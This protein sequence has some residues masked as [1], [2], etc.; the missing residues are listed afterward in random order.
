[1]LSPALYYSILISHKQGLFFKTYFDFSCTSNTKMRPLSAEIK[2]T[3]LDPS[4][5]KVILATS[6]PRDA[7]KMQLPVLGS[8]SFRCPPVQAEARIELFGWKQA[9]LTWTR[10][11]EGV[12]G[13]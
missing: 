7:E 5:V 1:M 6:T 8:H 3:N 9:W 13:G 4:G 10:R 11:R 12:G 2:A